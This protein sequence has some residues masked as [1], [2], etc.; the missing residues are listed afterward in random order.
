MGKLNK[1]NAVPDMVIKGLSTCAQ[2]E[3]RTH[4]K[5]HIVFDE[6]NMLRCECGWSHFSSRP[7]GRSERLLV[8]EG[9]YSVRGGWVDKKIGEKAWKQYLMAKYSQNWIIK[10]GAYKFADR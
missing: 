1:T 6:G 2:C 8:R 9:Y 5:R 10:S 4:T 7:S 3:D